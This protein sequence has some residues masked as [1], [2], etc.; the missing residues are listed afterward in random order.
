[1]FEIPESRRDLVIK[2]VSNNHQ[3]FELRL[4]MCSTSVKVGYTTGMC[5]GFTETGQR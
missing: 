4:F 1:M 3:S 2:L 5:V